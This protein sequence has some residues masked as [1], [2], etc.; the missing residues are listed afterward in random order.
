MVLVV[1]VDQYVNKID[2]S[3][4]ETYTYSHH[5]WLTQVFI[6]SENECVLDY[7]LQSFKLSILMVKQRDTNA[8]LFISSWPLLTIYVHRN[9]ISVINICDEILFLRCVCTS[10]VDIYQWTWIFFF[11]YI[12]K[13]Y[14]GLTYLVVYN[15][16]FNKR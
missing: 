16:S 6:T 10:T 11:A 5:Q 9:V 2:E 1:C 3:T 12:V 7:L 15:I 13:L 14:D 4:S 8:T